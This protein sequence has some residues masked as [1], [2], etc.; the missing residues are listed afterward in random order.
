MTANQETN[1]VFAEMGRKAV[2]AWKTG[3]REHGKGDALA[4]Y[5]LFN[6]HFTKTF[7]CKITD[8]KGHTVLEDTFDLE[9]Y[10]SRKGA[11]KADG[12]R[13]NKLLL[14]RTEAV[15]LEVF[16]IAAG[17]V[18]NAIKQRIGRACNVVAYFIRMGYDETNIELSR[19]NELMVPYPAM[20][21]PP[22]DDASTNDVNRYNALEGTLVALDGKDG[23]TLAALN[24]RANPPVT[25]HAQSADNS[26]KGA[27]FVASVKFS[28]KII[29]AIMDEDAPDDQPAFGQDA[30]NALWELQT[31]LASYF[32]ADPM[33]KEKE[34]NKLD[35]AA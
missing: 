15:A 18:T 14:A 34:A 16:G 26:N 31:V 12:T 8:K 7:Q 25:R 23:M 22:S 29:Q 10:I 1:A 5:A 17:N 19:R 21:S 28:T 6:A 11:V 35:K 24:R 4:A 32:E 33:E 2:E 9:D 3:D 30:R 20:V 27:E 13:D